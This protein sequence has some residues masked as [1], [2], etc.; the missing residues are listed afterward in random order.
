MKAKLVKE[1]IDEINRVPIATATWDEMDNGKESI[2]IPINFMSSRTVN[3]YNFDE[4]IQEFIQEFGDEGYFVEK[5]NEN[6]GRNEWVIEESPAWE[7]HDSSG[8]A[9][10]GRWIR[11]GGSLD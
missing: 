4:F 2:Q 6:M 1:S 11:R 3:G 10:M 9:S 8:Q 7:E 5:W